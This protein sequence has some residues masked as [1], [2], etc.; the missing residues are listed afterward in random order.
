M[1]EH[2][3]FGQPA[4]AGSSPRQSFTRS[5]ALMKSWICVAFVIALFTPSALVSA[6]D[7]RLEPLAEAAPAEEVAPEIVAWLAPEGVRLIRGKSRTVVDL[8]LCEAWPARSDF[9]PSST[10]IYPFEVG[11]LMGL[12]R[13]KS[14]STDF[15]GQAISPGVY[16]IRY[17][18][19]PVDGNHVG[20]SEIRDFLVLTPAAED[21]GVEP[22]AEKELNTLSAKVAGTKHPTMLGLLRPQGG[23]I[24]TAELLHHEEPDFWS[25]RTAGWTT[26]GDKKNEAVLDIVLVGEA[27]H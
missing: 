14:K 18:H 23:P 3:P 15:R 1:A 13:Y 5:H 21:R 9:E 12:A 16:V 22:I 8:W 26:A 19:Q 24:E 6:A 10:V 4:L 17:A 2:V 20:T 25:V 27:K 7:H 11:Q